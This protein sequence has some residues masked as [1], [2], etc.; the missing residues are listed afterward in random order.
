MSRI[1]CPN[2]GEYAMPLVSCWDCQNCGW[3]TERRK[4][5]RKEIHAQ[6][7]EELI[8]FKQGFKHETKP[9]TEDNDCNGGSC[10]GL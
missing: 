5:N 1:K 3:R 8:K 10:R 4:I 6:V 9:T 7:K 2:C